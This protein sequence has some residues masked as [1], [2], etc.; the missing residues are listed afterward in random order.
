MVSLNLLESRSKLKQDTPMV[1]T[2]PGIPCPHG[3]LQ[4]SFEKSTCPEKIDLQTISGAILVTLPAEFRGREMCIVH[5]AVCDPTTC[6]STRSHAQKV[7]DH[8]CLTA[9]DRRCNN[10]KGSRQLGSE[11]PRNLHVSREGAHTHWCEQSVFAREE[12]LCRGSEEGSYLRLIGLC[13]TQL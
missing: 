13:I 11:R 5:R 9:S 3:G 7:Q 2:R 12:S 10:L 6:V 1:N 8:S 4:P